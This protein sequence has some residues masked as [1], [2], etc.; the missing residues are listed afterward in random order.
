MSSTENLFRIAQQILIYGGLSMIFIG[1]FG[2]LMNILI[3]SRRPLSETPCS[4]Y[5]VTNGILSFLFLPLYFLPNIMTFGFENNWLALNTPFCKFQM[6]YGAFTVTSIFVINCLISF[7]RYAMSSRLARIRSY[8][9]KR[10]T[11]ILL[12]ISLVLVWCL[13]GI[14]VVVLFENIP[15]DTNG[16]MMCSTQSKPLLIFA[17]LIYYPILEGFLPVVLAFYFWFLT[18]RQVHRLMNRYFIRQFDKQVT[19]MCFYQILANAIAS[20]PFA[21]MNLYRAVTSQ[22]IRSIDHEN[23]IQFFRLLA[24]CLFY[25]QYCTDFYIYMLTSGDIRMQAK[26]ILCFW[27]DHRH[28]RVIPV[29]ILTQ[30]R[31]GKSNTTKT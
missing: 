4:I 31:T 20:F 2:S 23:I 14:P 16:S 6:S 7:D 21:T 29:R 28:N 22:N 30:P 15:V 9:S 10:L 1:M 8:S 19:F 5:L 12:P 17:A 25:I 13:I 18:R 27:S 3:F 26:R 11:R 24:I